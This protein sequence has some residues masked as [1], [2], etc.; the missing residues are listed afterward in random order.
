MLTSPIGKT[1]DF[2]REFSITVHPPLQANQA[3]AA[4]LAATAGSSRVATEMSDM[5]S[6]LPQYEYPP[7][8]DRPTEEPLQPVSQ[9][10]Q[11]KIAV[12]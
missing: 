2:S 3:S 5:A 11:S 1:K 7:E 4:P 9:H 8:Y 12:Y 10:E 6:A